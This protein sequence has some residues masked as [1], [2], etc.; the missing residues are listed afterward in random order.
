MKLDYHVTGEQRRALVRAISEALGEDAV[1]QGA[2]SFA[3]LVDGYSIDRNG[4]VTCPDS[5]T[6]EGIE[7]LTAALE[8]QGFTAQR[9]MPAAPSSAE[10]PNALVVELPRSD[11]SD[12][13]VGN[14]RKIVAS[15]ES[16]L[17]K[18]LGADALPIE[19][20]EGK[21]C[22]PWFTLR[23]QE[24]EADAYNRLICAIG[25]MAREQKRVTA[26]QREVENEKFTMRLF[27]IRLGFIGEEYK[28]A[29][30]ILL[31]NLTGNSSWKY[32]AP[33]NRRAATTASPQA[34]GAP[35]K[36]V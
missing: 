29:R 22:F 27:L 11:F 33:E 17:R 26:R 16:V 34:V 21:L 35:Y 15:K 23:G 14:L 5:A 3:Y 12:E 30:R 8:E 19:E 2:P 1:Y 31:Q 6:G 9:D 10:N 32:G 20:K 18:A 24:G 28:T 7:L 36:A 25:R 13:A 4:V